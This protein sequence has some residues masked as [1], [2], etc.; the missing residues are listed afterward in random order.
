M[1]DSVLTPVKNTLRRLREVFSGRAEDAYLE[2][3]TAKHDSHEES[4]AAGEAHAYGI[5]SDDVRKAQEEE[6]NQGS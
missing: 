2:R 6:E 5:A 4:Y 1:L 3:D